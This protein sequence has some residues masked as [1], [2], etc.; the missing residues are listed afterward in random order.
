MKK[1]VSF[2]AVAMM[3]LSLSACGTSELKELFSDSNNGVDSYGDVVETAFFDF[4]VNGAYLTKDYHGYKPADGMELLVADMTIKNS[5]DKSIPMYDTDFLVLW[6]EDDDDAFAWPV[7]TNPANGN[8]VEAAYVDEE[9]LPAEY[10]LDVRQSRRG[11]LVFAVPE[12]YHDFTICT[13]DSYQDDAE[14]GDTYF[15]YITVK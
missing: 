14:E 9:Q 3:V 8:V 12:G 2:L 13:F 7:T 6:G 10:E 15:V 4:S 5:F 1:L 11:M